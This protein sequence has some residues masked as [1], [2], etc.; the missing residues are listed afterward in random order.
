MML[1]QVGWGA[2]GSVAVM[3][4]Y[5]NIYIFKSFGL[6]S[7]FEEFICSLGSVAVKIMSLVKQDYYGKN[8]LQCVS[9]QGA[10]IALNAV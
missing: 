7:L 3:M 1:L 8:F 6:R 10:R 2:H 4:V 9:I 5:L